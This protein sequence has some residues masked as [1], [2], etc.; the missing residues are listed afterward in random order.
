MTK[1]DDSDTR[2]RGKRLCGTNNYKFKDGVDYYTP[3]SDDPDEAPPKIPN[4]G[5]AILAIQGWIVRP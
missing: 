1:E 4:L 5:I 3:P 2:K